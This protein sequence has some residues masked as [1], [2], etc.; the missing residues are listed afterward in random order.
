MQNRHGFCYTDEYRYINKESTTQPILIAFLTILSSPT[1][2]TIA[3]AQA[4]SAVDND[5]AAAA[6]DTTASALHARPATGNSSSP[7][8]Q[9]NAGAD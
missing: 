1:H 8:I 3:T 4:R 2:E 5:T 9:P 7:R 6:S